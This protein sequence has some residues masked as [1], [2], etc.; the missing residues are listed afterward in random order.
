MIY[1]LGKFRSIAK[2]FGRISVRS[3]TLKVEDISNLEIALREKLRHG[4]LPGRKLG[5]GGFNRI[6]NNT[7]AVNG[8][9]STRDANERGIQQML[10]RHEYIKRV[11]NRGSLAG[12]DIKSTKFDEEHCMDM[13]RR[14]SNWLLG[15]DRSTIGK[16]RPKSIVMP[17]RHA[18][19]LQRN[20]RPQNPPKKR[21]P[22]PVTKAEPVTKLEPVTKPEPVTEPEIFSHASETDLTRMVKMTKSLGDGCNSNGKVGGFMGF[23]DTSD[24]DSDGNNVDIERGPKPV[25][26]NDK[27]SNIIFQ[28]NLL[29]GLPNWLDRLF[30]GTTH[31]YSINYWPDFPTK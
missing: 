5:T 25:E 6:L 31:R 12:S 28:G 18:V 20:R 16:R 17:S 7:F 3:Y 1:E 27:Y 30:E 29:D 22:E 2:V 23:D 21:K 9:M 10:L 26:E 8:I 24:S 13:V 14:R 15:L 11:V 4:L 19:Y